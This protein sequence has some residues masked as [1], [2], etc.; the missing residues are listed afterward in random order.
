MAT[1]D[2][3]KSDELPA[4]EVLKV[5]SDDGSQAAEAP[6][7]A[8][9]IL[10]RHTKTRAHRGTYRPSHKATFIGLAVV[11][12]VLLI[13]GGV[14]AVVVSNQNQQD[15]ATQA[16]AVTLSS[17]T[18]DKLGVSRS[19]IGNSAEELSIGPN[20]KFGGTVLVA[21][22]TSITGQLTLNEK[23]SGQDATFATLQ[24]GE[25]SLQSLSVTEDITSTTINV[26]TELNVAGTS[27]LQGA[28]TIGQL[29]TV[30]GNAS[31]IGNL[32][33]G[34]VLTARTFQATSLISENSLTIGGHI[35]TA[36][37]APNVGKGSA[38]GNNGSVSISGNDA[39]GT[40]AVN[41]GTGAGNGLLAQVAFRSAYAT[42]PHV[43]ITPVG[44][45]VG[46]FYITRSAAGFN[47]YVGNSISAGGYA[48][49]YIVMQ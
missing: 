16:N 17:D 2:T 36:G 49:D 32:A 4:P 47:I 41:A 8:P 6:Q 3:S 25:T 5:Q 33:V 31:V 7:A 15:K 20:T 22:D 24:A 40:V 46:S 18:L 29:L 42:T 27:R 28:V 21:G 39:S 43:V 38:T 10:S 19:P 48:F 44:G 13:N 11:A 14:I 45:P 12:G 9:Q 35:I 37:S 30:S 1:S 23:L 26:Q 34:G